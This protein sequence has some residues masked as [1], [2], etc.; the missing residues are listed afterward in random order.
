MNKREKKKIINN[1]EYIIE[2]SNFSKASLSKEAGIPYASLINIFSRG[3][4]PGVDMILKMCRTLK[5][6]PTRL[7]TGKS[8]DGFLLDLELKNRKG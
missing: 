4:M 3:T 1:I 8:D 7:L 2:E 6:S 5:V